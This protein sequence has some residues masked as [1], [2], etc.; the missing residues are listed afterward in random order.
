MAG[1]DPADPVTATL[2]LLVAAVAA[3]AILFPAFT[4]VASASDATLGAA[5]HTWSRTIGMDA[6]SISRNA[7][8]RHP[9]LMT[10]SASRFRGDALRARGIVA[11]QRPSSAG[12]LRA[13]GLAVRAFTSY[14]TAGSKWAASGRARVRG[15]KRLATALAS[16]AALYARRGNRL[17]L[18]AGKLLP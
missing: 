5:L 15:R 4:G 8:Q 14:A 17:L 16:G 10:R 2:R 3:A 12:G 7:R 13:R 18:A 1:A 11:R 9:R 6:R